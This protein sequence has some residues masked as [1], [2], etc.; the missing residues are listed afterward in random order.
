MRAYIISMHRIT[1]KYAQNGAFTNGTPYKM[2]QAEGVGLYIQNSL[3]YTDL[4]LEFK[5]NCCN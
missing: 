1:L 4:K 3:T 5:I 2:G